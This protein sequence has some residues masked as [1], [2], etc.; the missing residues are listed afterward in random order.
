MGQ[1]PYDQCAVQ[2][3][4]EGKTVVDMECSAGFAVRDVF[5]QTLKALYAK[6]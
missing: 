4:N 1:I 2:A 5:N 3:V 6:K